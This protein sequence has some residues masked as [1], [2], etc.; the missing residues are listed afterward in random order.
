MDRAFLYKLLSTPSVSGC[1]EPNQINALA[2]GKT[3]A[4]EQKVDCVGNAV[5]VVNP[6]APFKVL[7]CG[8]MDEIGFRV[9]HIQDDGLLRVQRAGGVRPALYV[10][11]VMQVVHEAEQDGKT[12]YSTVPGV[13]AVTS[14]LVK[15]GDVKDKDL[16]IDI[17][18]S[19]R[20]EAAAVV[21]VG[22]AVC[23]DTQV[24][25]LMNGRITCRALDDKSGAFVILE[26]AKKAA[27][28]GARCGI[29]A[30]TSVGEETTGRGAYVAAA[31]LKPDCA[32]VVDVTWASDCPGANPGATGDV[33]LGKGPV[34]CLSGMVNKKMNRL[35]EKTAHELG[36][37]VQYEVA[38]GHTSTDGDT[39][40]QTGEGV[41]MAL[42]SVPLRYMHSS[43]EMASWSDIEQCV[44][45]IA[46]F[47]GKVGAGF[48]FSPLSVE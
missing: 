28:S 43:V 32:I 26:A 34:L 39:I 20:E 45:L 4:H 7:L 25:E 46:G 9:T 23:A 47:L 15:S 24:R 12:V 16:L 35:L 3:F 10:G 30:Q 40:L 22:D 5:S 18:A 2:F 14:D 1:E 29:Y 33:R 36:I 27:E 48:D 41:P 11:S 44:D 6:E 21:S 31:G 42:V 8:H 37:G 19:S 13:V 17:G 38:G